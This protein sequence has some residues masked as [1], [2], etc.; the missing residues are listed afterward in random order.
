MDEITF[1]AKLEAMGPK[2]AWVSLHFP[3]QADAKLG[4]KARVPVVGTGNGF[5]CSQSAA[6]PPSGL[7]IWPALAS[8]ASRWSPRLWMPR[9][10]SAQPRRSS[11]PSRRGSAPLRDELVEGPQQQDRVRLR[12]VVDEGR[13]HR[14]LEPI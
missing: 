9:I 2:G 11:R 3:K 13:P 14:R 6:S 8:P 7:A 5:P 12:V 1:T 4:T 10:R